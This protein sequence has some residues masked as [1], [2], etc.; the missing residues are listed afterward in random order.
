LDYCTAVVQTA[1]R[2]LYSRSGSINLP[3]WLSTQKQ[4]NLCNRLSPKS[5][6]YYYGITNN[7][8]QSSKN[9]QVNI[10]NSLKGDPTVLPF[11]P[12]NN[13]IYA[14]NEYF[15]TVSFNPN[16]GK[17]YAAPILSLTDGNNQNNIIRNLRFP[18]DQVSSRK[19]SFC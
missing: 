15:D 16:A 2:I 10:T 9:Q 14:A 13:E 8:T 7:K 4:T 11:N 12:H 5:I 3:L 1:L 18:L 19:S 6:Q 17:I